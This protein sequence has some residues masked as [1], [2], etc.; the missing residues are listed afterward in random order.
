M[1]PV[2]E[3]YKALK[4]K[5]DDCLLFYRLGDFYELFFKDAKDAAQLLDIALTKRSQHK[6]EDIP[7]CGVPFHSAMPYIT[8]LIKNGRKVAICEQLETPEEAK[9]RGNKAV[10]HRD[11]VRVITPGTILEEHMLDSDDHNYLMSVVRIK[12]EIAIA[13]ADISTGVFLFCMTNV[14]SL[15]DEIARIKPRE[16]IIQ[17]KLLASDDIYEILSH[18]KEIFVTSYAGNFFDVARAND[19]LKSFYSIDT[20]NCISEKLSGTEVACC[21]SLIEYIEMTQKAICPKIVLPKRYDMSSFMEI[22]S[23]T[24]ESLEI[25]KSKNGES[26][27]SLMNVMNKTITSGGARLLRQYLS[28]PL[29]SCEALEK[30]LDI[31]EF[32][33]KKND[34]RDRLQEV[35][36]NTPDM[37]R[38]LTR[39]TA[40]CGMP[41][42]LHA[43]S[44]GLY[45]TLLLSELLLEFSNDETSVVKYFYDNLG[46][47]GELIS[48]LQ[49]ALSTEI[50]QAVKDGGV[51][52]SDYD[53]RLKDLRDVVMN[54]ESLINDLRDKYRAQTGISGLKISHNNVIG[55]FVEISSK[56]KIDDES[57]VYKQGLANC[58][59][60]TTDELRDLEYKILNARS[61]IIEVETEI[62]NDLCTQVTSSYA[63][64]SLAISCVAEIDVY[65]SFADIALNNNYVRPVLDDSEIF[66]IKAGRHP[67]VE[68][69]IDFVCNDTKLSQESNVYMITGPNMAGKST[70]LRQNALIAIMAQIGSFVPAQEAHIGIVDKIF[71]RVGASD[72]ISTGQSTFM[73]E[74]SETAN[75]LNNATKKSLVI[76]DEVGRGTAIYDGMSIAWAVIEH[77]HNVNRC[78]AFFATHYHELSILENS[79]MHMKCYSMKVHESGGKIIFLHEMIE[80]STNR[81]YGLHVAKLAGLPVI[82]LRRAKELLEIF[83]KKYNKDDARQIEIDVSTS[84][85]NSGTD[86]NEAILDYIRGIGLDD[87]TPREAFEKIAELQSMIV[88]EECV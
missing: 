37:M 6:G 35:L 8:K 43:I 22:D 31:V 25:I 76:L 75:I 4:Q 45:A 30:R 78:R 2:M 80:G 82:V 64:I 55:Y 57:F 34:L 40:G 74:M 61:N 12:T 39:V 36:K 29:V 84:K 28:T 70:F 5:Y 26:K 88:D 32:F 71:S 24:R 54:S 44:K 86:R 42:D 13:W 14:R 79:L 10:V 83:E 16:I 59:R 20:L 68:R 62:F 73:V 21:G 47:H 67:V 27:G 11:V 53:C 60:Y 18:H 51:I 48:L 52:S 33:L 66:M 81:S 3:Q 50:P 19:R 9:K 87:I 17:D 15:E 56:N 41:R 1:T 49:V 72:S 23:S 46:A 38:A 65:T 85:K 77:I 58:I 69:N 63:S 7:M